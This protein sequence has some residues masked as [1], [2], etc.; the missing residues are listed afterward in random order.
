MC[1]MR[2]CR[3]CQD[4]MSSIDDHHRDLDMPCKWT[5]WNT[6]QEKCTIR[7]KQVILK[8]TIKVHCEGTI[9]QFFEAFK[10]P[11]VKLC[12]HILVLRHQFVE[13]LKMKENCNDNSCLIRLSENYTWKQQ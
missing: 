8:R 13:Y 1:S 11:L 4:R 2:K 9:E 5:Q 12:W 3:H 7:D 6:V 10:Q